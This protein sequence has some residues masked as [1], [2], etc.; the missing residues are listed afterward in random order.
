M[1]TSNPTPRQRAQAA[2]QDF[3][4]WQAARRLRPDAD[5]LL[6]EYTPDEIICANPISVYLRGARRDL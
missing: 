2:V 4:R 3:L 6:P 1:P 5:D